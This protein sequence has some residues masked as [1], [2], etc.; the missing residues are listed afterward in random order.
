[1]KFLRHPEE[2][3]GQLISHLRSWQERLAQDF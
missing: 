3:G 2:V 1:M